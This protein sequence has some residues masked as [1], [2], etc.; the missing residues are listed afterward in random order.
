MIVAVGGLV[1]LS[2]VAIF[3]P[4]LSL[5]IAPMTEEMGW[6][7]TTISLAATI[8]AFASGLAGPILGPI[9]DRWGPRVLYTGGSIL[10][11][12]SLVALAFVTNL[13]QFYLLFLPGRLFSQWATNAGN[14]VTVANWFVRRR[15][16][17]IGITTL[18]TR[19]GMA[20]VPPAVQ[21]ALEL[22]GWRTTWVLLGIFTFLTAVLPSALF[23]RR[24]PEEMGL[25]PDG[26]ALEAPVAP[27]PANV[28]APAAV[29][30]MESNWR[31]AEA[32]RTTAFW[33]VLAS[34]CQSYLVGGALNLHQV[35]HYIAQG[36]PA[37]DA[38][39]ALTSFAVLAAAGGITWSLF[40][41]RFGVRRTLALALLWGGLSLLV[42]NGAD[43]LP[44]AIAASSL[45]GAAFGGMRALGNLVWSDYFG[46]RS[47]GSIRGLTF[48][49]EMAANSLGPLSGGI[50]FDLTGHYHAALLAY[51]LIGVSSAGFMLLS[52]PPRRPTPAHPR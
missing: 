7:R 28:A 52:R 41:E 18:G 26:A 14:P 24:R 51:G 36:L 2:E 44:M 16:R 31:P 11:S 38:V 23:L 42:M 40:A 45:Y 34:Q 39:L 49:F 27:P 29:A 13:W 20:I 19:A 50:V 17:A 35:P 9:I 48:P 25:A 33:L 22:V 12:I 32:A 3:N 37:R 10:T 30:A 21:W 43:T 47:G 46:R 1:A 8:A 6:N 15:G 5:F 4:V